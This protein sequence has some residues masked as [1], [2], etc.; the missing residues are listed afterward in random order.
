VRFTTLFPYHGHVKA[1][2][3]NF[4]NISQWWCRCSVES[5]V[6][7]LST[8][9]DLEFQKVIILHLRLALAG[10]LC[11][12]KGKI[13]RRPIEPVLGATMW[14]RSLPRHAPKGCDCCFFLTIKVALC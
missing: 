3:D 2:I 13:A 5:F 6:A 7:R 8:V 14:R 10:I 9:R 4:D 1:K 12:A 11:I